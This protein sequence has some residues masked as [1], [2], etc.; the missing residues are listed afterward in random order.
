MQ[1][2]LPKSAIRILCVVCVLICLPGA[3]AH[4][5]SFSGRHHD[6]LRGDGQRQ[7]LGGLSR[8]T[9]AH[10][11]TLLHGGAWAP[12]GSVDVGSAAGGT[13][14]STEWSRQRREIAQ[15]RHPLRHGLRDR[16]PDDPPA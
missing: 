2:L 16:H 3:M 9:S 1:S 5:M 13:G 11:R 4:A 14:R 12:A 15:V 10:A 7:C 8:H 6:A